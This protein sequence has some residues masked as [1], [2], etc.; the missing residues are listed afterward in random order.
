[1]ATSCFSPRH[2][3]WHVVNCSCSALC[4][5]VTSRSYVYI[6]PISF[7]NAS[8]A[9]FAMLAILWSLVLITLD[10]LSCQMT[11]K[12]PDEPHHPIVLHP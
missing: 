9:C 2:F 3:A 5:D 1:V 6:T 4:F 11:I 12:M 10:Y 8:K 7:H